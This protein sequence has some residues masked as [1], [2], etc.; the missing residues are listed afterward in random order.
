MTPAFS[1][2]AGTEI[3]IVSA[4]DDAALVAEMER[5]VRFID[6]VP[7]V[8]L[9]DV[10]YTCSLNRGP[11]IVALI[12]ATPA[13]LR[14]R[15]VS[16]AARLKAGNVARLRDRSGT[17]YFREHLLGAG[18]GRLAFVYPGVM[19]FYPDMMRDLVILHPECRAAFDELEEALSGNAEF[20]P[21]D[22]IFPPASH[23][24][25]DAD[26]FSSGAYAQALVATFA[27]SAAMTR[28][29]CGLGLEPAG[30]VGCAGGDLAAIMCSGAV[31][32]RPK[33]PA[34][35]K[36][37]RDIYK[38]VDNAVDHGG[39]PPTAMISVIMRHAGQAAAALASFPKDKVMAALD[40]SPRQ[41]IYA[42]APDFAETAMAAL[43][44]CGVRATKIALDR[45]FNTP[46]CRK[47]VPVIRK[48]AGDWIRHEPVCDVYS[49]GLAARLSGNPRQLRND[50]AERWAQPVRFTETIARMYADG[51]RVFLEVGPRELMSAAIEDILS[52]QEHAAI[53]TNSIHRRG[54]LQAQHAIAQL[55]A[56]GAEMCVS[57]DFERRGGK[58]IDFDATISLEVR[59]ASE[60]RLSRLF[61]RLTL[62]G[63]ETK[64]PGA[65]FL[66]EPKG[67]GA[68]AAQ[69]AAVAKEQKRRQQQFDFGAAY[70]LISDA[71]ELA[72]SP[73]VSCELTKTFTLNAAPFIGDS[74][75]GSSQ[76]SYSD[77]NLRGLVMLTIPT[78]AE[79]AAEAAMRVMPNRT[80]V[81]IEDFTCRRRVQF[82]KGRLTLYIRAERMASANPKEAAIKVQIRDDSENAAYTWPVMEATCILSTDFPQPVPAQPEPLF[83][84]RPVHW[85]GR[86]IYP[87]MLG[88]G[89]RLRGVT[90]AETWGEGGLDYE[91]EVPPLADN[92]NFTRFPIWVVNPLLLQI[93]SSGFLL[94][95]SHERFPGAFSFPCRMRRL[96]LRGPLPKEGARLNCYLRLTGVTPK[97]H[98]CDIIVTGGDGNEVMEI[99]GWEEITE[100]VPQALCEMVLQPATSFLTESISPEALGS[101]RTNVASAFITDVPYALFER[102]EELWL[103]IVS[104][105][106]L[107][108]LERKQF[109]EMTGSAS[110]RTEWLY[111]RL[112]AKEAIRRYLKDF[113]QAR[114]SYA[115]VEIWPNA[116]GK[117]N[118]IGAWRQYLASQLDIA[119]AHTSQFVVAVAAANY[120]VGVDVESIARDLSEEFTNGVFARDEL[121]LATCASSPAQAIIRFWCAKEAVSKTLGTGI[122]FSP[123]EMIISAYDAETGRIT[124]RLEGGWV[125]AFKKFRGYDIP[126]ATRVM[127]DHALA[128]C[129]LPVKLFAEEDDHA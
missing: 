46:L 70:P 125:E 1:G 120:R 2:T 51:Y 59:A 27:G 105:V 102:H 68:K 4:A 63:D 32:A 34:R 94:W 8:P 69:R 112:A 114:W 42:V 44:N 79:I 24:R 126:V 47:I 107:D 35:V 92:V 55:M 127:R 101:P 64:M 74:A 58:K 123:R 36:A 121:D 77:P 111:G 10:A 75:Y 117:P 29:L 19:S 21:S 99:S 22:F 108:S 3:V 31:G 122:R 72:S 9:I 14:A 13:D 39:L 113:H 62:L 20:T 110:R 87:A 76:L 115:D 7:D 67:R 89:K 118:A 38:I 91:V 41:R 17:Y 45:P 128:F 86:E 61:P 30:V 11:S 85:S 28:L 82:V 5:V 119:I 23:Y 18:K 53:A 43:A 95:R 116:A 60:M 90:F 97:S 71:D 56:L 66:A 98:I 103:K 37:I 88:Y 40:F 6:R 57:P 84:P 106:V 48:F 109:L 129:F 80:L 26:I 65:E 52:G 104:H 83:K 49:C 12:A 25:R 15:L 50:A 100:R 16:A 33:R 78:A 124:V 81:A 93:V 73:G 54:L 96:D